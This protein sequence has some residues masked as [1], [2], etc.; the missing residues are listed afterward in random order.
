MPIG[1]VLS[2]KMFNVAI[3]PVRLFLSLLPNLILTIHNRFGESPTSAD[4][5]VRILS[6][7]IVRCLSVEI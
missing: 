7:L 5:A 3:I 4:S 2:L 6:G 1:T